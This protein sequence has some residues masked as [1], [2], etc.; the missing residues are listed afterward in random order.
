VLIVTLSSL[1][2]RWVTLVGTFVALGLGVALIATMGLGL[3][4]T[5]D[6]PAQHPE[7]LAGAPVVVR[8]MDKLRV[9]DR[10]QPLARPR[11]VPADIATAL[12]R[13]GPTVADRSFPV[14]DGTVGHPWSIAGFGGYHL[15]A[16]HE[17]RAPAEVALAADPSL[18]GRT[19][20]LGERGFTVAGVL[21]P[22]PYE[23]AVFFAD[24][25]AAELS[26]AIDN[27]VVRAA[28]EAVR[29]AVGGSTEVQV[30][31]G[32][33]RRRADPDP[34][35]D[36][37]ALV[38]MNALLGTAG[39]VT[40]FVSVFVV[41]S[42][43]A[44]AV[45]Q[46][47][48]EIGLLRTVGATPRQVRRTMVAEAA[49]VGVLASAA[50][51]TLGS[52]GA[53]WLARLLVSE[54][55]APGWFSIGEHQWP[56]QVAFWTGLVVALAGVVAATVRAGRIGPAE[57]LREAAV[58]SKA[59]TAGRW[60]FGAGL[61]AT[62]LGLLCWRLLSDPGDALHRKTYTTQPMLLIIAVALLAPVL[63]RP[64][65]R[66]L[67]WLPGATGMLVR[68]NASGSVRRTAA[69]AA[70]VL[71][72]VALAGSLLGATA[73]IAGAKASEL[74]T[75]TASDLIV[76]GESLDSRTVAPIR[77][78]PGATVMASASTTVYTLEEGVALIRWQAQA[79]DPRTLTAVRHLPVKAG[80]LGDLDDDGIVVT[81]EWA[82]HR[83][84]ERVD[85]WLG[86][87]TERSLRIVAVLATGTGDNGAYV[88]GRNGG[89]ARVDRVDVSGVDAGAIAHASGVRVWT[90][91]Q[92]LAEHVPTGGRQT[93]VGYF[94]VLGIALIYTGIAVANTM[95]MAASDRV[96]DLRVL[97]LTGASR[98]QVLGL[99]V[100]E[101]LTV[102]LVGA[103]LGGVVTA[104]NLLGIWGA[105]AVLSAGAAIVVP[106][107]ILAM[108]VTA[109]ATVA[110]IAALLPAMLPRKG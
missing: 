49:V 86:D 43:F 102:V 92:W 107:Q 94:V 22:V 61:L 51:C 75:Q 13:I 6:A 71:V 5:L 109:C 77:A 95:V 17:P 19:I 7:R 25:T 9:G 99:V 59:M 63:I 46:R 101:A 15:I 38:A 74:R 88:T 33:D 58:D 96:G 20:T 87:G 2:V 35:R 70:P 21:A 79:V 98:R 82:E 24:S 106:W 26:P 60:V 39:G 56:Y 65:V 32:D 69:V 55:L 105:L 16:G 47:R 30:L 23:R 84:G 64:V 81:E 34:D 14:R 85:V 18:L 3:A 36:R 53:P 27:L 91:D 68:A 42:T 100:V 66:L 31:S 104:V 48:R 28:P 93:R 103:V 1:R 4:A 73:T 108:T 97:R 67:V 44:F 83:V 90:R 52:R 62:G 80:S 41:A 11:P 37:D 54:G 8:G 57:A 78:V 45:A 40:T 72:V 50:G 10:V 29:A 89:G 12:A 110:V 76:D